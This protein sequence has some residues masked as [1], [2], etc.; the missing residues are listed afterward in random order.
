MRQFAYFIEKLRTVKEGEGTLLDNSMIVYGSGLADGN[1]HE[2]H[3]L[4][5]LLA[6]R[7]GGAVTPGR[8]VQVAKETPMTNLYMSMLS[9]MGAKVDRIGDSTGMLKELSSNA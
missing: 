5:V 8:H 7:G 1:G 4:P 3:N 9:N 2:H 6:G